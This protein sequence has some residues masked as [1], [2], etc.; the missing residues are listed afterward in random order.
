MTERK[1]GLDDLIE[2]L[3][4]QR[5]ELRVQMHLAGAEA[6]EEWERLEKKWNRFVAEKSAESKPVRDAVEESAKDVGTAL[7]QVAEELKK[8]Y[9]RIRSLL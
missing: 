8:G 7:E 6:K 4:Q 1:E 9:Q 2:S 3:K 5:D